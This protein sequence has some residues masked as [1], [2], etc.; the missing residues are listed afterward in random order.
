[1][2]KP[3]I[4]IVFL[5][6]NDKKNLKDALT[7]VQE[8]K[9]RPFD[10]FFIDNASTDNSA[11]Y[12]EKN[13][14]GVKIIRNKKN[15]GYAGAY[16]KYLPEI[17]SQGYAGAV[18][19]NTDILAD[20]NWL[21]ELVSSAFREQNIAS[22]QPKIYL[23]KKQK[24]NIFNTCGNPINFLGMGYSGC[25]GKEDLDQTKADESA[26]YASGCCL[27]IKKAAFAK[28]GNLD[29]DFFMY[30]E[31]QDWGW[32]ARMLGLENIVSGKSVLW[33]KYEF[34]KNPTNK[35][36]FFFLERNRLFFI[37]KNYSIKLIFLLLPAFILLELGII[38]HSMKN[39]YF[40]K[41]ILSYR[42]TIKFFNSIKNK[43]KLIQ[44]KRILSD[45]EL[46]EKLSP[47]VD[48]EIIG[49]KLLRPANAMLELYY[50]IT[51]K[52]I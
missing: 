43:R 42:E 16:A 10:I 3:S 37:L 14:P 13:F 35:N 38:L 7:S 34:Q 25:Y 1:M 26:A 19:I 46:F 24:T 28:V 4:A 44:E 2:N 50:K 41:K 48:F 33:H 11:G 23:W 32:R 31:D 49:G 36:K 12:V 51:K 40:G 20:E 5:N 45:K 6:Y 30:L 47:R 21:E 39:G 9:Y 22:A 15:I 8:Q 52:L 27:L 29:G 17:F 18:L